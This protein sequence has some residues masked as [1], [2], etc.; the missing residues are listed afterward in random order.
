MSIEISSFESDGAAAVAAIYSATKSLAQNVKNFEAGQSSNDPNMPFVGPNIGLD[1]DTNISM[2]SKL[3]LAFTVQFK[4][5][6]MTKEEEYLTASP[7]NM[8]L[9]WM[10]KGYM[11]YSQSFAD[12]VVSYHA[13]VPVGHGWEEKVGVVNTSIKQHGK[14][15]KA[16]G[17]VKKKGEK[18]YKLL[19]KG[20]NGKSF[21][22]CAQA[23]LQTLRDGISACKEYKGTLMNMGELTSYYENILATKPYKSDDHPEKLIDTKVLNGLQSGTFTDLEL[24]W[25][26]SNCVVAIDNVIEAG[27]TAQSEFEDLITRLG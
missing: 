4:P 5:L 10:K 20:K 21:I 15:V 7:G 27:M 11:E 24:K 3:S 16:S 25:M 6:A 9:D 14:W 2:G 19:V 23:D 17:K 22:E 13:I 8:V 12:T 18:A 26:E 1:F